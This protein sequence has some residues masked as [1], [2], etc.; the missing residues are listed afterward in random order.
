MKKSILFIISLITIVCVERG[1]AISGSGTAS[2]PY[3]IGSR[4]DFDAICNN[5]SYWDNYI[6]LETN[7]D[8]QG[9]TYSRA[10]IAP[11]PN[12][13]LTWD[14]VPFTGVFDGNGYAIRNLSINAPSSTTNWYLGLIGFLYDY[15]EV[16][17]LGLENVK[18][19]VS[20]SSGYSDFV[21][22][23]CGPGSF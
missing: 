16:R 6:L 18:I 17:N 11:D 19:T 12:D 9:T 2:S 23:I 8:L 5:S 3:L 7:I 15:G 1:Q 4:S 22:G 21:G 13:G 20:G 14:G 10:P